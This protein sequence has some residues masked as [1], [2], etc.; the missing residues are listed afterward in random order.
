MLVDL[1][2]HLTGRKFTAYALTSL[3]IL[4]AGLLVPA[5]SV[6]TVVTGLA[7]VVTAFASAHSATDVMASRA[8]GSSSN[9]QV[10]DAPE[11]GADP[12]AD[13]AATSEA[14]SGTAVCGSCNRKPRR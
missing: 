6:T 1:T 2:S 12:G 10:R 11:Q 7:A 14:R 3:L 9:D 8:G 4:L 13:K 5:S